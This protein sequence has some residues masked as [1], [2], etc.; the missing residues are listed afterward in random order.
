MSQAPYFKASGRQ[1]VKGSLIRLFKAKEGSRK[2][3]ALACLNILGLP[4][5]P[6]REQRCTCQRR[7]VTLPPLKRKLVLKRTKS[8]I[9]SSS[10]RKTKAQNQLSLSGKIKTCQQPANGANNV[11]TVLTTCQQ[12]YLYMSKNLALNFRH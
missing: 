2:H 11:P 1:K 7:T 5:Q 3:E 9:Y 12:C 8:P 6:N 10:K 4:T